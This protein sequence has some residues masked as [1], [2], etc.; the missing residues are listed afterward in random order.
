MHLVVSL[1][2]QF[3]VLEVISCWWKVPEIKKDHWGS[4]A[5]ERSHLVRLSPVSVSAFWN[6]NLCA[7]VCSRVKG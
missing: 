6:P 4:N 3:K 5:L 1:V 7:C 2:F